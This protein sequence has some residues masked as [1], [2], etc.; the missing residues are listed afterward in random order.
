[1]DDAFGYEERGDESGE[2][3]ISVNGDYL[4][5]QHEGQ[6][7]YIYRRVP[8]GVAPQSLI[9]HKLHAGQLYNLAWIEDDDA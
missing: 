2:V 7:R 6:L 4:C 3:E 8:A 5:V 9:S 1:M